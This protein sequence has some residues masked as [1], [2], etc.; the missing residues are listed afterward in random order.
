[1]KIYISK[2]QLNKPIHFE[3]RNFIPRCVGKKWFLE[4]VEEIKSFGCVTIYKDGKKIADKYDDVVKFLNQL[5]GKYLLIDYEDKEK[6]ELYF[7][8]NIPGI[9][10][11][12]VAGNDIKWEPTGVR[13]VFEEDFDFFLGVYLYK[14]V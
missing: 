8:C 5:N 3:G 13:I 9:T 6:R 1:M 14:I 2:E 4:M 10:R 7:P 12:F 11:E